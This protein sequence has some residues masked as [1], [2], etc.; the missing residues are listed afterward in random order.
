MRVKI[1]DLQQK[2]NYQFIYF[3]KRSLLSKPFL[4]VGV[5]KTQIYLHMLLTVRQGA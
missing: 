3:Q 1:F 2:I 5:I 4:F